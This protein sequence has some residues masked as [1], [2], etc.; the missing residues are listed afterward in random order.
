M[1]ES[2]SAFDDI[3]IFVLDCPGCDVRLKRYYP[4]NYQKVCSLKEEAQK[5]REQ[6][7][8]RNHERLL[9]EP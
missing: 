2:F 6:M 1:E 8:K 4:F 3:I 5:N 9:E 7:D